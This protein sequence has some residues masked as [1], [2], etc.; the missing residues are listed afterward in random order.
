MY[1]SIIYSTPSTNPSL[2]RKHQGSY[3]QI[4]YRSKGMDPP[5]IHYLLKLIITKNQKCN[6][7]AA[8]EYIKVI[9][10]YNIFD[11]K[12]CREGQVFWPLFRDTIKSAVNY[13]KVENIVPDRKNFLDMVVNPNA[14][15]DTVRASNARKKKKRKQASFI[16]WVFQ[17]YL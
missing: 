1:L 17:I 3:L 12:S 2:M 13:F 14:H 7:N 11:T 16:S 10:G 5:Q 6:E 9:K 8:K 4:K 15:N